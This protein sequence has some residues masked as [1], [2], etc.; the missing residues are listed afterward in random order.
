MTKRKKSRTVV[1]LIVIGIAVVL[2]GIVYKKLFKPVSFKDRNY[3]YL[4]IEHGDDLET[5]GEKLASE[6][7][8]DD[9]ATFIWIA[10][11]MELD[12]NIHPGK[13][14]INGGMTMRRIINLLKY[15]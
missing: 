5:V 2:G 1:M 14:R 15:N 10:E 7:I 3:V 11:K 6:G 4:Y 13:F 12:S 8:V 9:E